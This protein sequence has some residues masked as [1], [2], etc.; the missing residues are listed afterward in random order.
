MKD[1][2]HMPKLTKLNASGNTITYLSALPLLLALEDLNLD[3]NNIGMAIELPK[4]SIYKE[5]TSISME[6]C[7]VCI[8]KGGSFVEEVLIA[9][10]HKIDKLKRINRKTFNHEDI[11]EANENR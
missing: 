10:H 1:L 4:L 6:G 8:H 2:K 7:P 3:N 9:L 5:L 11:E